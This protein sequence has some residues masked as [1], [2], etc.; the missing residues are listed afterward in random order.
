MF[1]SFL[2]QWIFQILLEVPEELEESDE[3]RPM[4][5]PELPDQRDAEEEDEPKAEEQL[6]K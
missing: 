4:F 5:G 6:K 1:E 3:D 2:E